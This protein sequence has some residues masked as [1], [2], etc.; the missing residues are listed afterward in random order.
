MPKLPDPTLT[1]DEELWYGITEKPLIAEEYIFYYSWAYCEEST[2]KIVADEAQ[3]TGLPVYVID[4]RKWMSGKYKKWGFRL[5]EKTGPLVF[6]NLMRYAKRVYV[7]SFHGMVF[8]YTFR[9]DYWLLDTHRD[10]KGLDARLMEFVEL[11]DA[12]DRIITPYNVSDIDQDRPVKYSDN[13]MLSGLRE[14]SRKFLD[15]A[16]GGAVS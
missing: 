7:E 11:L 2:S 1:V 9:K 14:E 3:K 15:E 8:A 13:V 10:L 4:P 16:V 6:L 12:L 5:Y